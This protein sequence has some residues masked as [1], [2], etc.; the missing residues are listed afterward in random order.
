MNN[1]F[2]QHDDLFI[3]Q[4]AISAYRVIEGDGDIDRFKYRVVIYAGGQAFNIDLETPDAVAIIE[5][6]IRGESEK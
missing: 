1:N 6:D 2:V 3:R 5:K 4:S